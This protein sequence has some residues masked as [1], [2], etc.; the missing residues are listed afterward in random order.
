[1]RKIHKTKR[2]LLNL[3]PLDDALLTYMTRLTNKK[4]STLLREGLRHLARTSP[5]FN[6]TVFRRFLKEE[7]V[8]ELG[9]GTTKRLE[10]ELELFGSSEPTAD[11]T[12]RTGNVEFDSSKD[13]A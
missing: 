6:M 11:A 9:A 10:E 7:C 13:F 4:N 2:I 1:M 8:P 12:D 3:G 5:T